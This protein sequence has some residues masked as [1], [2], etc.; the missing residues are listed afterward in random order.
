[1]SCKEESLIFCNY[2][3]CVL[4]SHTCKF[5]YPYTISKLY[6]QRKFSFVQEMECIKYDM[7]RTCI[8]S[9]QPHLCVLQV[10]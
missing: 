9:L 6:T 4:P 1:M 2:R 10:M 7:K 3:H 5:D 8:I